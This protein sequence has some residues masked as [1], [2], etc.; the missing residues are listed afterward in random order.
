MGNGRSSIDEK[1]KFLSNLTVYAGNVRFN[2]G[3]KVNVAK[4]FYVIGNVKTKIDAFN[5][6]SN[7]R[8]LGLAGE[9][10]HLH[11]RKTAKFTLIN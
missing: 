7:R 11:L 5:N 8:S 2:N 6:Y 4:Q 10:Q 1:S 9:K 3:A